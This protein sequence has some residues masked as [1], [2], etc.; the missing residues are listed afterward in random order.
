[1]NNMMKFELTQKAISE[2]NQKENRQEGEKA[3]NIL[4]RMQYKEL[5][6]DREK[7]TVNLLSHRVG[8]YIK[9]IYKKGYRINVVPV[10]FIIQLGKEDLLQYKIF[11]EEELNIPFMLKGFWKMDIALEFIFRLE[12]V[13]SQQQITIQ[14]L[15]K[16]CKDNENKI[17]ALEKLL[18]QVE[19]MQIE[20]PKDGKILITFS[21]GKYKFKVANN[22]KLDIVPLCKLLTR[23][24]VQII[25]RVEK[26]SKGLSISEKAEIE[27]NVKREFQK[28]LEEF[29]LNTKKVIK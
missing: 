29:F 3:K 4:E 7:G 25:R 9:Q 26:S 12:A 20:T 18:A 19:E 14:K 17:K 27:K 16:K 22:V 8:G 28:L 24:Y 11:T 6:V 10:C 5:E 13:K 23:H 15:M 1:M 2:L 21:D